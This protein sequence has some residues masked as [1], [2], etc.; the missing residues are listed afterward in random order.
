MTRAA[1]IT[2][3]FCLAACPAFAAD[4]IPWRADYPAARA[5]A[6]KRQL[7]LVIVIGSAN[8]PHCQQQD[9][10]TLADAAIISVLGERAI[11]VKIAGNSNLAFVRALGVTTYPTTVIAAPD[12][13][14]LDFL[15][16]YTSPQAMNQSLAK[17]APAIDTIVTARRAADALAEQAAKLYLKLGEAH[18]AAGRESEA[19]EAFARAAAVA[20]GSETAAE[21][22]S[23]SPKF[24]SRAATERTVSRPGK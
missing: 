6:I 21:A 22:S 10:T 16:G 12:G 14:I 24:N 3:A 17:H 9:S 15:A 20:P 18:L 7:P 1:L 19:V 13:T 5:E 4:T 8:C 2:T 23:R 11:P